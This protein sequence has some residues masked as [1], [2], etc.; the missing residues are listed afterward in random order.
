[1]SKGSPIL[2]PV[3]QPLVVS[4]VLSLGIFEAQLA[5]IE[6]PLYL[7]LTTP[8]HA[9]V[10]IHYAFGMIG[11]S[12]VKIHYALGMPDPS[13]EVQSEVSNHAPYNSDHLLLLVP[14]WFLG[15]WW[16]LSMIMSQSSTLGT[17]TLALC[18][19]QHYFSNSS[20]RLFPLHPPSW[21]CKPKR[22]VCHKGV[23]SGHK[24][25]LIGHKDALM[26]YKSVAIKC[27]TFFHITSSLH[28]AILKCVKI[29]V[30]AI[31]IG[32]P[33]LAGLWN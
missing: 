17:S 29:K 31:H 21:I 27:D 4:C 12:P 24:G 18:H 20:C 23:V 5:I 30:K 22:N 26:V 32:P 7:S 13:P 16:T 28:L 9:P 33:E 8:D 10:G 14:L 3:Q 19:C 25:A 2:V 6:S 11:L 1:M 15:Y